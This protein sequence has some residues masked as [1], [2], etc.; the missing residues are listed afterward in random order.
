MDTAYSLFIVHN[1]CWVQCLSTIFLSSVQ[2]IIYYT[3]VSFHDMILSYLVS[4]L[5]V[6]PYLCSLPT[7]PLSQHMPVFPHLIFPENLHCILVMQVTSSLS[8]IFSKDI[9]IMLFIRR[10]ILHSHNSSI[11]I[12]WFVLLSLRDCGLNPL[13]YYQ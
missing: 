1:M 13:D 2:T 12:N 6:F 10:P 11:V 8:I 5:M 7:I 4:S 3:S 9:F